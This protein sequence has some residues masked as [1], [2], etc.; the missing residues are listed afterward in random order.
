MSVIFKGRVGR[1]MSPFRLMRIKHRHPDRSSCHP[2]AGP[3]AGC[4]LFVGTDLSTLEFTLHGHCG[5]YMAQTWVPRL[6]AN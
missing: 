2:T 4:T 1:R 5:R 6:G 3:L